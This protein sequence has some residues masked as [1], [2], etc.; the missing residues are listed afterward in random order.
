MFSLFTPE[1]SRIDQRITGAA[2]DEIP[3]LF[4]HIPLDAFGKLLLDVPGEFPNI[5]SYLPRMPANEVQHTWTGN[6]GE[7]LLVQ[8]VAFVESLLGNY[9]SMTGRAV[10]NAKIL[11]YGCG[12][13]RLLRLLSKY[14]SH[15]RLF[16]VDPWDQSIAKCRECGVK[17]NLAQS[18]YVPRSLPFQEKFN[19][20]FAFSVFTHLSEKTALVVQNTLRDHLADD[21]LLAITVRPKEYWRVHEN[22]RLAGRMIPRHERTGYAFVP[23]NLPPIDGEITYGDSSMTLEY[24]RGRWKRWSIAAIDWN[25][26]DPFQLILFLRPTTKPVTSDGATG[27]NAGESTVRPSPFRSLSRV[28]DRLV[29]TLTGT[30]AS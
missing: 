10:E 22:G 5:R 1:L 16:G 11:D 24:I 12:W 8:S 13:G 17:G 20:I 25:M 29:R 6:H 9:Q 27:E 26:I 3:A 14:V 2:P 15:D 23:H 19:L 18:D 28:R 21:G 7:A 30:P 4:R